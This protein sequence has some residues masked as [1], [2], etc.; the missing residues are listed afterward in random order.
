VEV[1]AV[2]QVVQPVH[3]FTHVWVNPDGKGWPGELS[4]IDSGEAR[5]INE[6]RTA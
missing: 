4:R 5:A 3:F 1:S 6:L 2:E